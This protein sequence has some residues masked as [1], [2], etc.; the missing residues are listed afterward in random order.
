MKFFEEG[1]KLNLSKQDLTIIIEYFL[2]NNLFSTYI[3]D[4]K[5]TN[6]YYNDKEQFHLSVYIRSKS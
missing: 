1:G 2:N 5:V 6:I 3:E 4:I